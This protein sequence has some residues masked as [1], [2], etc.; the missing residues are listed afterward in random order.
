MDSFDVFFMCIIIL[1]RKC[2][3]ATVVVVALGGMVSRSPSKITSPARATVS[4]ARFT[5]K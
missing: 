5:T 2:I 4:G 1:R 3:A